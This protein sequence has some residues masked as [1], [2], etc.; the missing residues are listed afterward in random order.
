MSHKKIYV[1]DNGIVIVGS[2]LSVNA[3][4]PVPTIVFHESALI[5]AADD[6]GFSIEPVSICWG[7]VARADP[8]RL[9]DDGFRFD[10]LPAGTTIGLLLVAMTINCD[11]EGWD[12]F[13]DNVYPEEDEPWLKN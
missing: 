10:V 1:L 6:E 4:I 11:G 3:D 7:M 8:R 5:G 2:V 13:P 12:E 9:V